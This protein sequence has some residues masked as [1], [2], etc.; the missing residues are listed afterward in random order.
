MEDDTSILVKK[1]EENL[2]ETL[3]LIR[4]VGLWLLYYKYNLRKQDIVDHH[5]EMVQQLVGEHLENEF[6]NNTSKE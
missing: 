6:A 2:T 3:E 4:L 1:L 5:E